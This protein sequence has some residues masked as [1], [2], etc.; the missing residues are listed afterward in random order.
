MTT[1]RIRCDC[2]TIYDPAE[3]AGC[4]A[5]RLPPTVTAPAGPPPA[6]APAP[7]AAPRAPARRRQA[8]EVVLAGA[9]AALLV[10]GLVFM[11]DRDPDPPPAGQSTERESPPDPPISADSLVILRAQPA[12]FKIRAECDLDLSS[13]R[14]VGAD[15][16]ALRQECAAAGIVDDPGPPWRPNPANPAVEFYWGKIAADPGWYLLA[17]HELETRSYPGGYGGSGSGFAVS[18]EGILLTNAHVV[19][20]SDVPLKDPLSALNVLREPLD[21]ITTKLTQ[22][23]GGPCPQSLRDGLRIGLAEWLAGRSNVRARF[24]RAKVVLKYG[25]DRAQPSPAGPL[26]APCQVLAAGTTLPGKDVAVLKVY[27]AGGPPAPGG[28][29]DPEAERRTRDR[30]ICLPLGDS[31]GVLPAAR[32]HCLGFPGA[33]F[34]RHG[35]DPGAEFRVSAREGRVSQTKR[36]TGGWD[37]LEMD[38]Q[39]DHGDSGGPVLDDKGR[40]I[41]LNVGFAHEHSKSTLAV[42]ID[43]AREFLKRAGVNPDPGPLT[44]L[45]A[46]GLDVYAQGHYADALKKFTQ[47]AQGLGGD[48]SGRET[49][50]YVADMIAKCQSKQTG[51]G[52]GR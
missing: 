50:P 31:A 38:A 37:A 14:T 40:V 26:T 5:C 11:L 8:G 24:R 27:L 35:M 22:D 33:L 6:V 4:P 41:G 20:D 52:P 12:V 3:Q 43:L 17:S 34:N 48:A 46:E 1:S 13:P 15:L 7:V 2:G 10:G 21:Q 18:R 39:I 45:W 28:K 36:M 32:I 19:A 9:L 29:P 30:L 23:F 44:Q 42:P 16:L 47:V 49:S 25:A 51:G